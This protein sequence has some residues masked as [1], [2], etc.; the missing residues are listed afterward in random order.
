MNL[1]VLIGLILFVACGNKV[2]ACVQDAASVNAGSLTPTAV[3]QTVGVT[4]GEYYTFTLNACETV[5]FSFCNNG[6]SAGFD[7]QLSVTDNAGSTEL[8]Y[9]DDNCGLQSEISFTATANGTYKILIT[10]YFCNHTSGSTGT[11][12]YIL[13]APTSI[14]DYVLN[15]DASSLV[16]GGENCVQLTPEA[17][18]QLSCVWNQNTVDFSNP[19]SLE[20]T[21]YFGDNGTNGADGN[22]FV[23]KSSSSTCECGAA[24]GGMGAQGINNSIIVEFD[25][26]DNDNPNN[27]DI[28]E[29]H[30]AIEIDGQPVT[31]TGSPA[32]FAGPIEALVG[33]AEIDDG[34]Q[35]V[36]NIEWDPVSQ[37]LEVYFDGV[38]RLTA[39][40]DFITN[41]FGGNSDIT[42]GVTSATGG[43]N[44][45]QYFCPSN[46]VLPVELKSFEIS[47]N[48][49]VREIIWSTGSENNFSH[50]EV[51]KTFD[52]MMFETI[53]SIPAKGD[54][55][56]YHF[57]DL[58]KGEVYYRVKMVDLDGTSKYSELNTI[59]CSG[60]E[61][62]SLS[63]TTGENA[64][65]YNV[66]GGVEGTYLVQLISL[67]GKVIGQQEILH[68]GIQS[69]S[70]FKEI[71]KSHQLYI[72]NVV[73]LSNNDLITEKV[74][75]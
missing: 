16:V 60:V 3:A 56:N 67:D 59:A 11:M 10:S 65:Y 47:C 70:K 44:N 15:E 66:E 72:V 38:L 34:A 37:D 23:F 7:T 20:V 74:Y 28:G 69:L 2:S 14:G 29:D 41:V 48:S 9:N 52:G 64:I 21:Y 62:L 61:D 25:T 31:G 54:N 75:H 8:A 39:N 40:H 71:V 13:S 27:N 30:V 73:S 53:G 36:V 51:Q 18:D 58:T 6:G 55:S 43:L 17:N 42:W 5:T 68:N 45:Q 32:P 57:N 12:S 1:R 22:T 49:G 19:V 33:G 46:V 63:V 50:F 24:G 35:H 4:A 26:Y